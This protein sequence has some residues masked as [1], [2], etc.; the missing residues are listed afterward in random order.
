MNEQ[1]SSG[2]MMDASLLF[3]YNLIFLRTLHGE[4]FNFSSESDLVKVSKDTHVKFQ[5]ERPD[6][7]YMLRNL[8]VTVILD[9][10]IGGYR[11]IRDYDV[12]KLGCSVIPRR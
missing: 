2:L 4:G 1:S 6:D 11:T 7:V 3:K 5:A 8:E 10:K 12:F 9:F